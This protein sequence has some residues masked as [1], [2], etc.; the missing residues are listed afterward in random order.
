MPEITTEHLTN[1]EQ[2]RTVETDDGEEYEFLVDESEEIPQH[3]YQG[4][5][6][7]P[8]EVLSALKDWLSQFHDLQDDSGAGAGDAEAAAAGTTDDAADETA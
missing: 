5:G 8:A 7:P 3:E 1:G 4:D 6:D 2:I